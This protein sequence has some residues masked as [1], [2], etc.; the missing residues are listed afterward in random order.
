M[1]DSNDS[2]PDSV[3]GLLF[4]VED[5]VALDYHQPAEH[6]E[7]LHSRVMIDRL[8][9]H[10]RRGGTRSAR[11]SA[12][13]SSRKRA[14][15]LLGAGRE[16]LLSKAAESGGAEARTL[17]PGELPGLF[18]HLLKLSK[19]VIAAVNG[20]AAVGGFVLAM[21]C[22]LRFSVRVGETSPWR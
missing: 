17:P 4:R 8:A 19:P 7:C 6:A 3:T 12:S 5:G 22:D 14:R 18:V 16:A 9:C 2:Q 10:R 21:M 13:S 1:V 11:S 15:L 20:V